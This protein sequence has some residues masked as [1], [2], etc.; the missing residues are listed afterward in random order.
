MSFDF[1]EGFSLSFCMRSKCLILLALLF[2]FLPAYGGYDYTREVEPILEKYCYDCHGDGSDKGDMALDEY[3]DLTKLFADREKW[4]AVWKN[5]RAHVMPPAN[6]KQPNGKER[7]LIELWIEQRI[8]KLDPA[9]PDPGHVTVRRLN[10]REYRQK[11]SEAA[12]H[13]QW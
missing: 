6:K 8:F 2:P 9:N 10:R 4:I 12:S 5:V 1:V 3:E 7:E 11:P 13:W